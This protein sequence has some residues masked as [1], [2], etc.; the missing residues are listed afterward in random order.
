MTTKSNTPPPPP[1]PPPQPQPPLA[2]DE[3]PNETT[4][5]YAFE[6]YAHVCGLI[7]QLPS[8]SSDL[9]RR[10]L[11]NQQFKLVCDKY[12]EQPHLVDP[13]LA[14]MYEKLIGVVKTA[15]SPE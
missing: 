8:T 11:A 10:E 14:S 2:D 7:E 4:H 1:P 12:Q 9:R 6:E 15:I 3:C 13:Y 5:F